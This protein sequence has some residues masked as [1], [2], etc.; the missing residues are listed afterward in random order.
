MVRCLADPSSESPSPL[1]HEHGLGY[2]V[3]NPV[4]GACSLAVKQYELLFV[5]GQLGEKGLKIHPSYT[6]LQPSS[7][8]KSSEV[9]AVMLN[10]TT[11]ELLQTAAAQFS[12]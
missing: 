1:S 4:A 9:V 2:H 3:R 6:L 12:H 11:E 5:L 7:T 8:A 10:G